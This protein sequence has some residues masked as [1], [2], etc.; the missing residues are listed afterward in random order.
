MP[1]ISNDTE[2]KLLVTVTFF[3][4]SVNL[5][6]Q[7][8]WCDFMPNLLVADGWTLASTAAGSKLMHSS[9]PWGGHLIKFELNNITVKNA[10][11]M[12]GPLEGGR[13]AE[14]L[15][16]NRMERCSFGSLIVFVFLE[17]CSDLLLD[18][19]G[20]CRWPDAISSIVNLYVDLMP[21]MTLLVSGF[22]DQRNVYI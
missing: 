2:W 4:L 10:P 19:P 20:D 6:L 9:C 5:H 3:C 17:F 1:R 12:L 7:E 22:V 14:G 8:D 16:H 18:Y 13:M 15:R 21:F 11:K